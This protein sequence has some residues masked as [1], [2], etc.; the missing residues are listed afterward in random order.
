MSIRRGSIHCPACNGGVTLL[1]S[2]TAQNKNNLEQGCWH[3]GVCLTYV[4]EAVFNRWAY[5]A[6]YVW[7]KD[8]RE[9]IPVSSFC[10]HAPTFKHKA[11]GSIKEA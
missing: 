9:W 10:E 11:Q 4:G 7:D 1:V 8:T 3:C 2:K 6:G 5:M